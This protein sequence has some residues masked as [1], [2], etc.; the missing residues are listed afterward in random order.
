MSEYYYV[1][2]K[3]VTLENNVSL[4]EIDSD[5]ELEPVGLLSGAK[6]AKP[7]GYI[8]ITLSKNSG[9][10]YPD[11]IS[12]LITL[13]SNKVKQCLDNCGVDNVD[14]YPVKIIDPKSNTVNFDYWFANICGRIS[15]IDVEN[16]DTEVDP[17]GGLEFE[18]FCIDEA[19][20]NGAR[21]FRLHEDGTLV[22]VNEVI[23]NELSKAGLKGT[24]LE[25]TRNY[26]GHGV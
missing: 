18:S 20:V 23:F 15:C 5:I 2:Q 16:S 4:G 19:K 10:F 21:I 1:A 25:N 8:N 17:L 6:L 12:S 9:D 24:I 26:D 13:Y 7:P 11:I 3:I 22:I 14:F